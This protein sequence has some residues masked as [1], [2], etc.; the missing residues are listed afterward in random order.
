MLDGKLF[1]RLEARSWSPEQ[2]REAGASQSLGAGAPAG[3]EASG[4]GRSSLDLTGRDDALGPFEPAFYAMERCD[5]IGGVLSAHG[6]VC[7]LLTALWG[8]VGLLCLASVAWPAL[9]LP[10]LACA[11]A[12]IPI[13][14]IE[15]HLHRLSVEAARRAAR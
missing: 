9:V 10:A 12:I 6:R 15:A 11:L 8:A 2:L 1:Q 13:N 5:V 4:D 14:R 7:D 3:G